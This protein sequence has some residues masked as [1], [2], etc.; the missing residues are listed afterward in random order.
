[1]QRK[2]ALARVSHCREIYLMGWIAVSII[3]WLFNVYSREICAAWHISAYILCIVLQ[4]GILNLQKS[5]KSHV[6][7]RRLVIS[8]D[9]G[10]ILAA[11]FCGVEYCCTFTGAS[12]LV[13]YIQGYIAE[14]GLQVSPEKTAMLMFFSRR[15]VPLS[16]PELWLHGRMIQRVRTYKYLGLV[17]DHRIFWRPAVRQTLTKCHALLR[18]VRRL[19]GVSWGKSQ[20]T[21]LAFFRSLTVSRLLYALPLLKIGRPHW[22]RPELFHRQ[23]IRMCLG[24]PTLSA[25]V[26]TLT[27]AHTLPLQQQAEERAHRHLEGIHRTL[28]TTCF[29]RRLRIR[30][31]SHMGRLAEQFRDQIG[32][33]AS[34]P[35]PIAPR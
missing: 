26:P 25:I 18:S 33:P 7:L 32:A 6:I 17:M 31:H 21:M 30:S 20:Y 19:C 28:S 14:Q 8:T 11:D 2:K 9:I 27:E 29:L 5:Y 1:M 15:S 34:L 4:S 3:W 10:K 35:V 23:G 12:A 13:R 24:L 22:E 16:S